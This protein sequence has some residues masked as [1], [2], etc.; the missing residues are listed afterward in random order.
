MQILWWSWWNK[1]NKD[2]KIIVRPGLISYN[3]HVILSLA[4]HYSLRV[5][6]IKSIKIWYWIFSPLG[7]FIGNIRPCFL[8]HNLTVVE[9][10]VLFR[11]SFMTSNLSL[12]GRMRFI[13]PLTLGSAR[14]ISFSGD[15]WRESTPENNLGSR[16]VILEFVDLNS[17]QL[18]KRL[19][20]S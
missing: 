16:S 14:E 17:K 18:I 20:Y 11:R 10:T 1:W 9:S 12:H 15:I 8:I 7:R 4:R 2:H 3:S 19:S 5:T 13:E 6:S